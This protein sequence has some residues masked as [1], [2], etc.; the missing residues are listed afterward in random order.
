MSEI[1]GDYFQ[2]PWYQQIALAL[3]Y[4]LGL[5]P[6]TDDKPKDGPPRPMRVLVLGLGRCGTTCQ[7]FLVFPSP[8]WAFCCAVFSKS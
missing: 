8:A 2:K 5:G 7:T 1:E 3:P 4:L 6:K